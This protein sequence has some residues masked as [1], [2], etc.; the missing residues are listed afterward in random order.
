MEM[1]VLNK[2]K[3]TLKTFLNVVN[4][5]WIFIFLIIIYQKLISPFLGSR[6]RFYPTCSEYAKKAFLKFGLF[7]GSYLGVKRV[8]K[9]HPY[10]PGGF[11]PLP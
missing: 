9:C 4:L 3:M 11:D 5:K 8:L 7:K 6:C 2:N 1:R 10:N